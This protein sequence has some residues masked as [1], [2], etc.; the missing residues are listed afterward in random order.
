MLPSHQRSAMSPERLHIDT[1]PGAWSERAITALTLQTPTSTAAGRE[2][3]TKPSRW[4]TTEFLVYAVIAAVVIPYMAYV[5]MSLS[6]SMSFRDV[7]V[8]SRV[9]LGLNSLASQ[10]PKVRV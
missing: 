9:D 10:S 2:P 5:P 8:E 1:F 7:A 6:Q 4:R 3:S